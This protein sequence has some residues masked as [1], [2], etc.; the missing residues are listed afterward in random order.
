[1]TRDAS[2]LFDVAGV[3]L[4]VDRRGQGPQVL[5]LTA[6][7]HDAHDF[8]PLI[9]RLGDRFEFIRV[10]WPGHG[11][12]GPDTEP[13]SAA[14]YAWLLER[15]APMLGLDN[16]IIIGNSIGGAASVIYASKHPVGGLVLCNSGGLAELSPGVTRAIKIFEGFFAAGARGAWWY[17][18][19]FAL[20]YRLVLP[21]RAAGAQRR[22]IIAGGRRM[23]PVLRDAWASFSR[24]ETYLC[25]LAEQLDTPVWFAWGRRDMIAQLDLCRPGIAKFR[26]GRLSTFDA[27]HSAFLEQPDAFA[28]QF[29]SFADPLAPAM[30]TS[31]V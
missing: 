14:R 18:A 1:M 12:S 5:C 31:N 28:E 27:G 15:L 19:A 25:P 11:R 29:A 21:R 26:N 10:E 4:H 7:G 17:G 13:A 9:E 3:S 23:A 2:G 24:P 30:V 6:L 16:P 22:K 20:Y 8:D